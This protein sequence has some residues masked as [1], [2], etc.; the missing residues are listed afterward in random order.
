L[1]LF[2]YQA[3]NAVLTHVLV[4]VH[5]YMCVAVTLI[6]PSVPVAVALAGAVFSADNL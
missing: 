4:A 3:V 1:Y 5:T 6:S 2:Y